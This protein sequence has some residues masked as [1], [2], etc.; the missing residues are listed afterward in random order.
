MKCKKEL[1]FYQY[2]ENLV[3]ID[4]DKLDKRLEVKYGNVF[5]IYSFDEVMEVG[6]KNSKPWTNISP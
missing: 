6:N 1:N 3:V 5:K 2:C 4:Y